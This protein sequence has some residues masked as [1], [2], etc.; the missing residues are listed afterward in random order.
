MS[1]PTSVSRPPA[2]HTAWI[3]WLTFL[4]LALVSLIVTLAT[5]EGP[6]GAVGLGGVVLVAVAACINKFREGANWARIVLTVIGALNIVANVGTLALVLVSGTAS[7]V[8]SIMLILSAVMP[9]VVIA[10]L[11]FCYRREANAFFAAVR[12]TQP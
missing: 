9:L 3:L 12:T 6:G 11:S 4:G 10:A 1:L 7:Q 5:S 2:V 8:P